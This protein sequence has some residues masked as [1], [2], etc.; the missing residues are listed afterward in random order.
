MDPLKPNWKGPDTLHL[1]DRTAEPP[2]A[3]TQEKPK[4]RVVELGGTCHVRTKAQH[5]ATKR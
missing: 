5:G 4:G 1:V 3:P 2:P